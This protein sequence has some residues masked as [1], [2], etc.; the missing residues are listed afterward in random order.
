MNAAPP[1]R[2]ATI[3]TVQYL[4][5]I[6]ASLVVLYHAMSTLGPGPGWIGDF[7]VDLFFVISGCIMWAT[8]ERGRS[9]LAFWAA[10][11]LRIVPLYWVFTTL[12]IMVALL[13]PETVFNATLDALF[14]VKSYLF[15]PA[16]HPSL[17]AIVPVYSLGWTLNYEM[18]FYLLFGVC[19]FI[20]QR[21]P[22]LTI[23]VGILALLASLGAMGFPL[24]P[25]ATFYTRPILLD[26]AA[27]ILLAALAPRLYTM[28]PARGWAMLAAALIWLVVANVMTQSLDRMISVGV[29]A[30]VTVAGALILEPLAHRRPNRLALL[31]GDASYSI[32]LAHPFA[33]RAWYVA[34]SAVLG[35]SAQAHPVLL[36]ISMMTIGLCGGVA[37]YFA[38]EHPI[39]AAARRWR[40]AR[41]KSEPSLSRQSFDKA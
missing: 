6:A 16:S 20:P 38:I 12:Y 26:F 36:V 29:P 5:G 4:R 33:Q 9:P 18:F 8:T 41:V 23:A 19:L 37:A 35:S 21:L 32:Y 28:A 34:A 1:A 13:Q 40:G 24:G 2:P 30:V 15:V 17:G 11:I 22:R 14:I 10:R 31:V 25:A 27:G 3:I 7:G 39:L